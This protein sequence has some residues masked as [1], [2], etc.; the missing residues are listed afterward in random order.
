[1]TLVDFDYSYLKLYK[2][3]MKSLNS[4]NPNDPEIKRLEAELAK[5]KGVASLTCPK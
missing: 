4:T 5:L 2:T 3:P 1:M